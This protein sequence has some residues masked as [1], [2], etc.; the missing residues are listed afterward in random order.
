MFDI[1]PYV[2]ITEDFKEKN[3]QKGCFLLPDTI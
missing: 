2:K 1:N 3:S